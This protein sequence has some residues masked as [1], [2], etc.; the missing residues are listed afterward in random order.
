MINELISYTKENF[1]IKKIKGSFE[2]YDVHDKNIHP[3]LD[4]QS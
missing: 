4:G 3:F 2:I 1:E